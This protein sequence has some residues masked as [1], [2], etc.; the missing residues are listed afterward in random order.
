MPSSSKENQDF[1][2]RLIERARE[3]NRAGFD[4]GEANGIASL[5]E[6]IRQW[7]KG[8]GDDLQILIYGDFEPPKVTLDIPSLG[9]VVHSDKLENTVIRT[10]MCVLKATVK[11]KEKS[12]LAIM[13]AAQR[14]NVLLGAYTLVEWGN[15]A[16][17]WWSWVTHGTSAGV[18]TKLDHEDLPMAIKGVQRL[19]QE[20]RQKIDAAL[21]W[22][23][24]PRNTFMEFYRTDL[25][26]VYSAYWNAFECL[27]EA[28]NIIRPRPTLSKSEKQQLIDQIINKNP[29]KLTPQII[30]ECY[31]DVV[32][33][34]FIAKASHALIVCFN[35]EAEA[36]INECFKLSEKRDRLYEIRNAINHGNIDAENPYELIRVE[37]RLRRLWM[38]IWRI[39]GKLIPF[40]APLDSHL[41]TNPSPPR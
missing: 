25:L 15:S 10:A 33:P 19:P 32:N 17:G 29:G 36:Y 30:Q 13:D 6:R 41:N 39:F 8:W 34:G 2:E 40:S 1:P 14:I 38:I 16:C 12:V 4:W 5:E 18:V 11:I 20:V 21:Y 37:S 28:V 35:E 3:L 9:I 7:P 24:E 27:V 31:K 22:V 23:R 26:R